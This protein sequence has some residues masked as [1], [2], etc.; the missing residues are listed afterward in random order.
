MSTDNNI[1]KG[2]TR[3]TTGKTGSADEEACAASSPAV[4][5]PDSPSDTPYQFLDQ[6]DV[7]SRA[8][9][10]FLKI[11]LFRTALIIAVVFS[12]FS[13][14]WGQLYRIP[15]HSVEGCVIDFDGN[16]VGRAVT[17][18]L[19]Q[20]SGPE[21]TWIMRDAGDFPDG[22]AGVEHLVLQEICWIAI[23]VH[24]GATKRFNESLITGDKSYNGSEAITAY[25]VEA[26]NEN[27]FRVFLKPATDTALQNI[28][29]NFSLDLIAEIQSNP[30]ATAFKNAAP[31]A[32]LQP[33]YYT[34]HNLRPFDV[35]VAAA[36]MFVG[37]IYLLI[38][39]FNVVNSGILARAESRLETQLT[40]SSLVRLRLV[41]PIIVY[42]VLS[43]AYS[44]VSL[45]FRLPFHRRFGNYGFLL[46]WML[47][48]FG[49]M[50]GGLALETMISVLTIKYVQ[51]FLI[52]WIISNVSVCLWPPEMLP[53]FYR[54][55]YAAPFYH[56][57]RGVRTIVFSTKN[58]LWLNFGV[59]GVWIL[60][61]CITLSLITVY[62]RREAQINLRD[63]TKNQ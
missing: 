57:S 42:F 26:R 60:I 16:R 44:L 23:A 11:L 17:T 37:L 59:L 3:L 33:I 15:S 24:S 51:L 14:Y 36:V 29:H 2:P 6:S 27:A 32:I 53:S 50:A 30:N 8:R 56:L 34:F 47:S 38:L 31:G 10:T 12:V 62:R 48:W 22:I 18:G 41:T 35:P 40:T 5:P 1:D 19:S 7:P 63:L 52:L 45:A 4:V 13:I 61:S 20:K 39:A 9:R 46:F 21:I 54:Y 58:E 28:I 25:G 49:M 43:C 55:A